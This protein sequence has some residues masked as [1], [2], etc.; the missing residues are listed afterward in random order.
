MITV[1]GDNCDESEQNLELLGTLLLYLCLCVWEAVSCFRL[2]TL[3][4]R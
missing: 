1:A 4:M 3:R 2:G